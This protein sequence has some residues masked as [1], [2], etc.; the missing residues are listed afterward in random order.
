MGSAASTLPPG[1]GS[2]TRSEP[3]VRERTAA[4]ETTTCR[5]GGAPEWKKDT[6]FD[7]AIE[8]VPAG[9]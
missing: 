7:K 9:P 4:E 5:S 8:A 2:G 1:T 3:V 6:F